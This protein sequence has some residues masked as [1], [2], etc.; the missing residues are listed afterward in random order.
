MQRKIIVND[1]IHRVMS[2]GSDDKV[3]NVLKAVIDTKEFQRLRRISQ[4][5]LASYVFPGATHTRFSHALGV[6]Y[7]A[8]TVVNHLLELEQ[9]NDLL[10]RQLEKLK[11]PILLSALLHDLGHGPFSHSFEKVLKGL[12]EAKRFAPLHEDWSA[13][14]ICNRNSEIAAGIRAAGIDPNLVASPF[15]ENSAEEYP[16][17][18]KQIV[19]S[20]LDVDRMDYLLRD[21][22]FSGVDCGTFDVHYLINSLTVVQHGSPQ[23]RTLGLSRKGIKVYENYVL[24]RHQMNRSVYYHPRV[25]V[26]EF[27]IEEFLR[28]VI[29][30]VRQIDRVSSIKRIVPAYIRSVAD[31]LRTGDK[32]MTKKDFIHANRSEYVKLTESEIWTLI[33]CISTAGDE[34]HIPRR[35][36]DLALRILKRNP[37]NHD[38]IQSGKESLLKDRLVEKGYKENVDFTIVPLESTMYKKSKDKV[39]VASNEGPALEV[40]NHSEIISAFRDK[41]EI[42]HLLILIDPRKNRL[43]NVAKD[44]RAIP[45]AGSP[46]DQ[47]AA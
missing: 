24:A 18:L 11:T 44:L 39:F 14:L 45:V 46:D 22:H 35:I 7:L 17:F 43:F 41:A 2:F 8:S 27:M 12:P 15:V 3:R 5:G 34:Q 28:L 42:E 37:L 36:I 30:N 47:L 19:S 21:A 1:P 20:Q 25:K 6:A 31:A 38:L 10:T 40:T 32:H 33:G 4:L 16:Q 13:D 29:S 9:R 23:V 26:M